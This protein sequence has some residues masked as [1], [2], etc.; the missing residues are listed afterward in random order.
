MCPDNLVPAEVFLLGGVLA[1][2]GRQIDGPALSCGI[3]AGDPAYPLF[4][5]VVPSLDL[6]VDAGEGH[7][8][9][10]QD[11]SDLVQL[12]TRGQRF[13]H[14]PPLYRLQLEVGDAAFFVL[15]QDIHTLI[16]PTYEVGAGN[17]LK[18]QGTGGQE[19]DNGVR[20]LGK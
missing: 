3:F 8:V 16:E 7:S 9:H 4:P 17:L 14:P 1:D 18:H 20:G 6:H 13:Q 15:P 10:P 5:K 12:H 19:V 2:E 11:F